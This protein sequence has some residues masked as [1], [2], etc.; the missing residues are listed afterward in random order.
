VQNRNRGKVTGYELRR[1]KAGYILSFRADVKKAGAGG[2]A[3]TQA[4]EDQRDRADKPFAYIARIPVPIPAAVFKE[5][6][7]YL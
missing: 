6:A 4:A 3:H 2:E 7:Y 1:G 5:A